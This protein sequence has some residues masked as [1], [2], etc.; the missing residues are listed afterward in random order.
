[1]K[2]TLFRLEGIFGVVLVVGLMT[3]ACVRTQAKTI[4]SGP[5]LVIKERSFD[6]KEVRQGATV[7]HTFQV[8]NKGDEVLEIKKL[9]PS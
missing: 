9:K 1:M 4:P 3:H 5:L 2:R 7:E 6:F 8:R